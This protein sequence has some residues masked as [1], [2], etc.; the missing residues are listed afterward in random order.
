MRVHTRER[1]NF[2]N[3]WPATDF[4][5]RGNFEIDE[6]YLRKNENITDFSKYVLQ[7]DPKNPKVVSDDD[8]D[9][10]FFIPETVWK[11]VAKLRSAKAK[12]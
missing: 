4:Y 7:D 12:L 5:F 2:S 6:L 8:I 1:I 9:P 10:D 3:I 11:E